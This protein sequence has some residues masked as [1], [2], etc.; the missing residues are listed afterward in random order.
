MVRPKKALTE[1]QSTK[2]IASE[3]VDAIAKDKEARTTKI[4][5]KVKVLSPLEDIQKHGKSYRGKKEIIKLLTGGH[6]SAQE[7]INAKCYDCMGWYSDEGAVDC[8]CKDCPLH[9]KMPYNKS[10]VKSRVVDPSTIEKR[11]K[12]I[13][14]KEA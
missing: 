10:K 9:P 13:A 3:M 8:G 1:N 2:Q 11:K 14:S 6:L 7:C 4:A 5:K 12:T